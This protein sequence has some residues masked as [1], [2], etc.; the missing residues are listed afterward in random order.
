[1]LWNKIVYINWT[2]LMEGWIQKGT[3]DILTNV[4]INLLINNKGRGP[5]TMRLNLALEGVFWLIRVSVGL[6]LH[7][8]C[9]KTFEEWYK[10]NWFNQD[11]FLFVNKTSLNSTSNYFWCPC[12]RFL[13]FEIHTFRYLE[14]WVG[15]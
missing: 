13:H 15:L 8:L 4:L 5:K 9:S 6:L 12:S 1:M 7:V 2:S 11:K 3:K 14:D 10:I